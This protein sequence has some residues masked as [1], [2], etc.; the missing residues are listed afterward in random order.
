AI[1]PVDP[2]IIFAESQYGALS[3]S[4]DGG[5]TFKNA[6][7]P[8]AGNDT[9]FLF[10]TPLAFDPNDHTHLWVGGQ[11]MWRTDNGVF[12]AASA[13]MPDNAFVSALAI[14]PKRSTRVIGGTNAGAI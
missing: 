14:S 2:T 5:E 12:I 11:T 13:E 10:V 1:D 8:T 9:T 6:H 3:R 7:L 4:D